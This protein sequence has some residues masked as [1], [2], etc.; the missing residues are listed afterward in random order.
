MILLVNPVNIIL[1]IFNKNKERICRTMYLKRCFHRCTALNQTQADYFGFTVVSVND[2]FCYCFP[3]SYLRARH[4]NQC[5]KGN[6]MEICM[7]G[8]L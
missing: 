3:N 5:Q 2:K 4:I 8:K 7:L 6:F 1:I